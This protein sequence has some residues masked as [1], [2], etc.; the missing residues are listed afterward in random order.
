MRRNRDPQNPAV[1]SLALLGYPSPEQGLCW[2]AKPHASATRSMT[3]LFSDGGGVSRWQI[4]RLKF[5]PRQSR[6]Y[7]ASV[8]R[9]RRL[10]KLMR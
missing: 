8:K 5:S 4:S 2:S 6:M 7:S 3:R 1:Q 9:V 10:K